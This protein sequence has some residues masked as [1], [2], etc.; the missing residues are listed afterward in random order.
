[1]NCY[2]GFLIA[3][4]S[5][6]RRLA[7]KDRVKVMSWVM[8]HAN[9]DLRILES[10]KQL[11]NQ[12]GLPDFITN[13]RWTDL[14]DYRSIKI[15]EPW[16]GEKG[17][18][19][20]P[21][22]QP[23]LLHDQVV[24]AERMNDKLSPEEWKP[25]IASSL[26]YEKKLSTKRHA[27]FAKD[28]AIPILAVLAAL[29]LTAFLRYVWLY[30]VLGIFVGPGFVIYGALRYGTNQTRLRLEADSETTK[31]LTENSLLDVLSKIQSLGLKEEADRFDGIPSI[32]QRIDNL[33]APKSEV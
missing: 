19:R 22:Y 24:L 2:I 33:Q 14:I 25:L 26:I 18:R 9:D 4:H 8:E 11:C 32:M 31:V 10:A 28:M 15:G 27:K 23:L 12:L 5:S 16:V 7:R 20:V 6:R 1:M 3:K 13:V 17:V 21:A 29:A 30:I